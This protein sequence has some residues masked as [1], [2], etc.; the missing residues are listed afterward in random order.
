MTTTNTKHKYLVCWGVS[1]GNQS[2]PLDSI[3][4]A[5]QWVS[6]N[7]PVDIQK[8]RTDTYYILKGALCPCCDDFVEEKTKCE[9]CTCPDCGH[10]PETGACYFC[11]MD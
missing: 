3:E 9:N 8:C 7:L 2:D 4:L 10:T 1:G 6:E 5:N 11:K